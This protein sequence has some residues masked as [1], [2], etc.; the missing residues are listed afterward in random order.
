[1]KSCFFSVFFMLVARQAAVAQDIPT[2]DQ[3]IDKYL[4]AIGGKEAVAKIEDLTL[5]MT[6]ESQRNGQAFTLEMEAKQK[7]PN[8]FMSVA[9][10][11]GQEVNRTTSNGLKVASMRNMMGNQQSNVAEGTEATAQILQGALFPEL[12]YEQYKIQKNVVG[13][14]TAAGK[15]AWKVEFVTLEGKKWTEF[16]DVTSGLKIRRMGSMEGRPN[17]DRQPGTGDPGQRGGGMMNVTF[18]D[19]KEAK[20]SGGVKIPFTR[21]QGVGGFSMKITVSSAKANKGFKDGAFEIK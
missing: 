15:E 8:K 7:K 2:A 6:G 4:A 14:D 9:Y 18:L 12:L 3:L 21:Q 20:D 13:K 10:A 19:Y 1:M 17:G 5:S 11:F 16:F